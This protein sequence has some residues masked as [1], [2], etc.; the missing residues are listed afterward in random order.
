LDG[1]RLML[2]MLTDRFDLFVTLSLRTESMMLFV[3]ALL[4]R[5]ST[6]RPFGPLLVR[7]FFNIVLFNHS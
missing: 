4:W 7:Q 5:L 3:L 1:R 2:G 6:G